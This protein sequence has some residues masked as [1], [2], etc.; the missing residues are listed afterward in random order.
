MNPI[1]SVNIKRV[2]TY[3]ENEK[4]TSK[5]PKKNLFMQQNY[6]VLHLLYIVPYG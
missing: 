2:S 6:A 1:N 3:S 5:L 4:C